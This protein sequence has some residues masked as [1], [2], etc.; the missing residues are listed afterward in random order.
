MPIRKGSPKKWASK[1]KT[2]SRNP[3]STAYRKKRVV[4]TNGLKSSIG[5]APFKHKFTRWANLKDVVSYNAGGGTVGVKVTEDSGG[6]TA[7]L[8]L[9]AVGADPSGVANSY[10]FGGA[11]QFQLTDLPAY[12]DFQNLFD[13][14]RIDQVD[15]EVSQVQ[16]AA[17]A[18]NPASQMMTIMYA[19]D[20]DDANVPT[21]ASNLTERQRMKQWTFR[22]DGKPLRISVQP[23]VAVPLY[24]AGITSPYSVASQQTFIDMADSDV[25]HYGLKFWIQD[26]FSSTSV[27]T[28]ETHL[29]FKMKY[30]ISC[31]DPQ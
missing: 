27:Y 4:T 15:I 30:H 11:F 19:P 18:G 25:P 17:S 8:A 24:R 16:N 20:F 10:T 7:P 26:A 22:G 21:L 23:R 9:G 28:G 3:R 2:W 29:R 6:G 1:K 31:K 13:Q 14:Y 12:S 5:S